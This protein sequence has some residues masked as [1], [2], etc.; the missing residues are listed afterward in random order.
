MVSEKI[1]QD[2]LWIGLSVMPNSVQDSG[3]SNSFLNIA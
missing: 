2:G 3:F 1:P